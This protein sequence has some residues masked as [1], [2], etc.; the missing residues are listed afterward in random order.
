MIGKTT[1][2]T[3]LT[4]NQPIL[5]GKEKY[6]VIG[7]YLS[8]DKVERIMGL[9]K[10]K[11]QHWDCLPKAEIV[12]KEL[13]GNVVIGS[14]YVINKEGTGSYGYEYRP[15]YEF[16]AWVV[17]QKPGVVIDFALPGVIE[18]GLT[19]KDEICYILED[20]EPVILAGIP[21]KWLRYYPR[22]L[23]DKYGTIVIS[24]LK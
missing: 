23:R 5:S 18:K 12:A 11:Y 21:P 14:T 15:P 17:I 13:G 8:L 24:T 20:I 10:G 2:M 7:N 3:G 6:K 16:H 9:L 22:E 4:A 1:I 19:V